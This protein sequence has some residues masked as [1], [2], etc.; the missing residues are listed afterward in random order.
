M[1]CARVCCN[2]VHAALQSDIFSFGVV[3]WEIVTGGFATRGRLHPAVVPEQCPQTIADLITACM[4]VRPPAHALAPCPSHRQRATTCWVLWG[5]DVA[6]SAPQVA[7]RC[8]TVSKLQTEDPSQQQLQGAIASLRCLLPC[9][10]S[11][12]TRLLPPCSRTRTSV[13]RRGRCLRAC[14]ML[15]RPCS[16]G[17]APRTTCTMAAA[18]SP[19]APATTPAGRCTPSRRWALPPLSRQPPAVLESCCAGA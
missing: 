11:E 1:L 2:G 3:L 10:L 14:A 5:H 16:T 8:F 17:T 13:R 18:P 15:R 19:P 9:P 12:S 6:D 7:A 4:R